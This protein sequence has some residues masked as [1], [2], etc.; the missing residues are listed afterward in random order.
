[1]QG[2]ARKACHS[3]TDGGRETAGPGEER[4]WRCHLFDN[5]RNTGTGAPGLACQVL[6]KVY[7]AVATYSDGC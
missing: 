1:M 7:N 6:A 2:I 3:A 5:Q 4:Q